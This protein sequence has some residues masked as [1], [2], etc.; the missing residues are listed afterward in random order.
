MR[1]VLGL[2]LVAL[3]AS[4]AD[5]SLTPDDALSL[6]LQDIWYENNFAISLKHLKFKKKQ[7]ATGIETLLAVKFGSLRSKMV[8][9]I[10]R[11]TKKVMLESYESEYRRISEQ[12]TVDSLNVNTPMKS[13]LLLV[14]QSEPDKRVDVY[15]DCVHQ[16]A[17]RL[18]KSFR[19]MA[20]LE[21]KPLVEV[22]RERRV[23]VRVYPIT[24]IKDALKDIQCSENTIDI[25]NL[26]AIESTLPDWLGS[27]TD[28]YG[29]NSNSYENDDG[30][31]GGTN[32]PHNSSQ[33]KGSHRADPDSDENRDFSTRLRRPN[34]DDP[35]FET[36]GD[37][38][39]RKSYGSGST[40]PG[41]TQSQQDLPHRFKVDELEKSSLHNYHRTTNDYPS[42][43]YKD[44]QRYPNQTDSPAKKR[45][46]RRGD[47]GIQSLDEKLCIDGIQLVKVLNELIEATRRVWK[48]IELNRQETQHLRHL[49]ENC[50]GCHVPVTEPPP[51]IGC[52]MNSPCYPG[53]Y[54]RESPAGPQCGPCPSGMTGN[55]RVCIKVLVPSCADDPCFR[56]VRC[57][58][59]PTGY[60]C[61]PC[62]HGYVGD[63][64][65]CERRRGC[66]A[67]PCHQSVQCYPADYPPFYQCG[68]C[69]EG[70]TGNG[71]ICE[72]I[73]E[74]HLAR[75]CHRHV[76]CINLSP[77][78]RCEPCPS[79]YTGSRVEGIG[80]EM[81]RTQRQICHDVDE[82]EHSNGGCVPHSQCINTEGSFRCGPC[83]AGFIGN[84]T[85]G[86]R[87]GHDVCPDMIT[88]CDPNADCLCLY[89]DE[90][91]C[92]CRI[93]WAGNGHSCGP[94]SDS[95]G[96]P[97]RSL[98]CRDKRCRA[99]NCI[100][101][102]NSG[103]E[104][105]DGDGIGDACDDDSDNDGVLNPSDNCPF[106]HNPGQ[107]DMDHGGPDGIGDVCDNCPMDKNPRQE[108]TDGDSIGDACDHDMDDDA[109]PN[110][111]DNCP[112]RKNHNQLD[113][114][115]DGVGDVCDN[116]PHISNADQADIDYDGVG[117]VCDNDYD[118]DHD[119]IQ[120]DRDNCPNVPNPGQNDGDNDNIGDACDDD[121]DNDGVPNDRDNCLFVYNPD[122][123]DINNDGI[124]DA[125]WNDYDNDTVINIHDNCP[126]NSLVWTTDFRRYT[127]VAL[128]PFG[129]SQIDP[130]WKI[131][132]SGAEILETQNSDPGIAIGPDVFS[133]VDFE[134]TFFVDTDFDDDFVGFVFSY[135]DNRRFYVV[136]WKKG[137]QPYWQPN[138]FRAIGEPGIQLKLVESETGPGEMLRNSLWH[139]EDTPNQVKML[140]KDPNKVGWKDKT[141]YRWH[142]MHRP[143]IGLIRFWLYQ[144]TRLV[145]D[146]GNVYD[147]T[148]KGGRLGVFCFSQ[149]MIIW[150][151]LLYK[152]KE[153][154][155]RSVY[156]E[157]LP[158]MK[159]EVSIEPGESSFYDSTNQTPYGG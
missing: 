126:N 125:C 13:L 11:K 132:H 75:P 76:Q 144:G 121:I 146:S 37:A 3:A 107:E 87:R 109:I 43:N 63:G 24:T 93:G 27:G 73:N 106:T 66:D 62:P 120:D 137:Y 46:P 103:Q 36:T 1:L 79:G 56:G 6:N 91:T 138:P 84:Q 148:L 158:D 64:V 136:S 141:P 41:I 28:H 155:P 31:N 145:T 44:H 18:K 100:Y 150:S 57:Y 104:D 116:C 110:R 156:E 129:T 25:D 157:L 68:A 7:I 33:G 142:L 85:V 122:Q 119:G 60:R 5:S 12:I 123:R 38:G 115:G 133:G 99:D 34:Q 65:T 26:P 47:I 92:R 23:Q 40:E 114:D 50:A 127:T 96:I 135:Q 130:I 74:C 71:T 35:E 17:M 70:S 21:E 143:R 2:L 59:D 61:G 4:F 48:E 81:A 29:S 159:K 19:E 10:D 9:M 30:R 112:L 134:G 49:I 80:L 86:C 54:C 67:N 77:G 55:G 117:N 97:D 32:H 14:R 94:D 8:L 53:A 69:S 124:G 39:S 111:Q 118:R 101:V 139:N 89:R 51:R 151:D 153:T 152:C 95:D 140:W 20:E 147:S 102:P 113:S 105:A 82:C 45:V 52:D 42:D 154:V 16:G 149:E 15:V 98:S 128:D 22:F 108:D 83:L 90:Y 88:I 78:Y 131:H 58:N 72:D